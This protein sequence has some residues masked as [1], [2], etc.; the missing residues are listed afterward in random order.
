MFADVGKSVN[1]TLCFISYGGVI[2]ININGSSVERGNMSSV[3]SWE[4]ISSTT[5][6]SKILKITHRNMTSLEYGSYTV[7]VN[8]IINKQY[9][10]E[11]N[12]TLRP[13]GKMV[14]FLTLLVC[15]L[16]FISVLF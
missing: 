15:M 7:R 11:Y 13:R 6:G 16:I 5:D 8:G 2:N 4:M 14:F 12:V 10:L 1:F 9:H 3:W